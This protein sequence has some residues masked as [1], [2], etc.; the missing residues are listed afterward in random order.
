M[1]WHTKCHTPF[2]KAARKTLRA[3]IRGLRI[4]RSVDLSKVPPEVRFEN[5]ANI[6]CFE[7][8]IEA[9]ANA[10]TDSQLATTMHFAMSLMQDASEADERVRH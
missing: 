10:K 6:R 8:V 7:R 2:Q 3:A 9:F 4:A 5:V 1:K